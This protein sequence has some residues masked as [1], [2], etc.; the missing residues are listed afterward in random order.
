[1]SVGIKHAHFVG[2]SQFQ[3]FVCGVQDV[4]APVAQS[5]HTK[6]VPATPL[7]LVVVLVVVVIRIHAQPCIPIHVLRQLLSGGEFNDVCIPSVPTTCIV[8]VGS[9]G[10]YILN[11]TGFCP[12]FELEVVCFRVSLI[13]HLCHLVRTFLGS[14]H[15]QFGFVESACQWLFHKHMLAFGQCQHTDGEVRV[16]WRSNSY[17]FEFVTCF[18]EHLAE[19]AEAF[20]FREFGQYLLALSAVQID[21]AQRNNIYLLCSFKVANDLCTTVADTDEGNLHLVGTCSLLLG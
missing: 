4:C 20:C 14:I 12:S 13:T 16:V 9:D 2:Q 10:R 6:V 21:I 11:D 5:T 17:C 7:S 19:V 18:V 3:E 15:Q 8:H 1:M